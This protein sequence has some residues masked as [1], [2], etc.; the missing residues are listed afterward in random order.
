MAK[1]LRN[2]FNTTSSINATSTFDNIYYDVT[3]TNLGSASSMGIPPP[4]EFTETRTSAYLYNP[5]EYKLAVI[6]FTLDTT[7]LPVFIPT[8]TPGSSNP[9]QTIYTM[10]LIFTATDG[11]VYE[12]GYEALSYDSIAPI[13]MTVPQAPSQTSNKLQDNSSGFYNVYSFNQISVMVNVALKDLWDSIVFQTQSTI[14]QLADCEEP[15]VAFDSARQTFDFYFDASYAAYGSLK[16]T[17]NGPLYGIFS[18]LPWTLTAP[19]YYL[20]GSDAQKSI[21]AFIKPELTG[22]FVSNVKVPFFRDPDS[23][24]NVNAFV[25][26]MEYSTTANLSPVSSIVFCSNDIPVVPNNFSNPL[27]FVNN[28]VFSGGVGAGI[29][30]NV[31]TDF[32]VDGIYQPSVTYNPSAQ[33]RLIDLIGDRPLNTINISVFWKTNLGTLIPFRLISGGTA[34]FKLL[35]TKTAGE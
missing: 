1:R 29:T 23:Q 26:S 28:T 7:S 33:Y 6:R 11:T 18:S 3:I 15:W 13:G 34:T 19:G 31:I 4:L 9:F 21:S 30:A 27:I 25:V 22:T 5:S 12:G 16:M 10:A 17:C 2:D 14:P 24:K 35:F 32:A 20:P 8:I